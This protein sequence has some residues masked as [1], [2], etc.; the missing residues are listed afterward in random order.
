VAPINPLLLDIVL[1]LQANLI[2]TGDGTDAFRDYLPESPDNTIA[3]FEY[4]GAPDVA[5]DDAVHRAV[6]IQFRNL[7]ADLARQ[8]SV[9]TY[10]LFREHMNE[11]RFIN[12]SESRWS[13]MYLKQTPYML[14]RDDSA[15]TIYA[16]NIGLT[17]TID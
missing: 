17:T 16:F 14:K 9:T 7:D 8:Q 10:K 2:I 3:L 4:G 15:R 6:Q 13:Q 12:L 1:F 5:V 11:D